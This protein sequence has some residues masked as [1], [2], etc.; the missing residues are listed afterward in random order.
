MHKM[1]HSNMKDTN[2]HSHNQWDNTENSNF[3]K[4]T[5]QVPLLLHCIIATQITQGYY[6]TKNYVNTNNLE[7]PNH[8]SVMHALMYMIIPN[9]VTY[10]ICTSNLQI[11]CNYLVNWIRNKPH[12]HCYKLTSMHKLKYLECKKVRPIISW[13]YLSIHRN[14]SLDIS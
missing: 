3:F 5:L 10:S 13:S 14:K 12:M 7:V 6:I 8:T 9:D 2:I 4:V 1:K 11:Y